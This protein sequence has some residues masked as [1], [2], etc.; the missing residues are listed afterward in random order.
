MPTFTAVIQK[1]GSKGEKTGWAYIDVLAHIAAEI[2]PGTKVSF[3]VKGKLDGFSIERAALIPMG[4]GDFILPVNAAM[5][6]GI[7]KKEGATVQVEIEADDRELEV[8]ADLLLC[9]QDEP[10]ALAFFNSL[11]KGHQNYFSKW[12]ESAKTFETRADRLT[13]TVKGL[14]MH[15]DYGSMIR[16]FKEEKNKLNG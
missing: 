14:S 4:D 8:C 2:K 10:R 3:R 11:A 9:L 12:I 7:G 5:R 15:M 13:K 16:Y 1:Y 6:K